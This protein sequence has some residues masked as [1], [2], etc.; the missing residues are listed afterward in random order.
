MRCHLH[1][2]RRTH[3]FG[4]RARLEFEG[5][6]VK[7]TNRFLQTRTTGRKFGGL[8]LFTR[9]DQRIFIT[10]VAG[11]NL[12]RMLSAGQTEERPSGVVLSYNQA[13]FQ[14]EQSRRRGKEKPQ[15]T[16]I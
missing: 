13:G 3:P 10:V 9:K 16:V 6:R 4:K 11:Q 15:F 2:C 14:D 8:F 5:V 1:Q 12:K 7:G